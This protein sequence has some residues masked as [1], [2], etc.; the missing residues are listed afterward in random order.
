ME[1]E[2]FWTL[3]NNAAHWEFEL[4]L[5]F[6]FDVVIGLIIWPLLKKK[7]M[8]HQ[9]DDADIALLQK[10]VKELQLKLGIVSEKGGR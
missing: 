2:T 8:H 3:I 1:H 10:Q 5:M 4:F 6:I 9:S 7:E